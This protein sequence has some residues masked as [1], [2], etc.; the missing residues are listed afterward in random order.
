MAQNIKPL[1]YATGTDAQTLDPQFVTD[2]PTARVVTQI[3]ETLIYP[4]SAG[5]MVGV[6]AESWD[7][8]EDKLSWTF[9]LRKGIKFHDGT[10][11]NAAA[12]K[13]TFDRI[14]AKETAAP[15]ASSAAAIDSVEVKDEHTVIIKTKSPYAP[16]LAQLSAYNLAIISPSAGVKLN[17]E[18]SRAPAGT[19]P[20]KLGKWTPGEKLTIIRN[21]EYWGKKAAS[22]AVEFTVVPEDSARVLM[23]MSGE[24]DVVSN[25]P[26]IMVNRLK[27]AP[28]V[29][30]VEQTGYRTI[31][32]GLNLDTK[33]FDDLKVRQAIAHAIDTKLLLSGVMNNIGTAGG[34]LESTVIPG[35]AK[36]AP[37]PYNPELSKKLLA[38]AGY[39]NGFTIDFYITTGRYINDKQLGEA[40]QAQLAKVGIKVNLQSPEFGAY[41]AM[42]RQKKIPMFLLGKGS[43]TGD[44]DFT[45]TINVHSEG[46]GNYGNYRNDKVDRLLTEQR[47]TVEVAKRNEQLRQ[48]LQQSY[49][50]VPW[51]VLFYENQIFGERENVR[52]VEVL[53]NENVLFVNAKVE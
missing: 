32:V 23:L 16:L 52:G 5:E 12:V 35:S 4:N 41:S 14:M 29:K 40:I 48:V 51:I 34:G 13:F 38:E 2:I 25:V 45:L 6:L 44:P 39:P 36:I 46:T 21:D 15:R 30:I 3:H 8:S 20:F 47:S 17:N 31:Y 9:H 42:L 49:D 7:V 33:P 43:P 26:P 22:A 24:A 53:P 19:G 11:F 18:Y 50:D 10:P 37:Y 1:R 28:G 27:G